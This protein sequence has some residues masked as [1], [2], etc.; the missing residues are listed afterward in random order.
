MGGACVRRRVLA[1]LLGRATQVWTSRR[2]ARGPWVQEARG[3][4]A[5]GRRVLADLLARTPDTPAQTRARA[6]NAAGNLAFRQGDYTEATALLQQSLLERRAMGDTRGMALTLNNLG[7]V[8]DE[9]GRHADARAFFTESLVL[10]RR[11]RR[12][13]PGLPAHAAAGAAV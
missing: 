8:A 4:A 3:H 11:V 13:T 7:L 2:P 5:E 9:Q 12:P 10:Q 1:R 6:L